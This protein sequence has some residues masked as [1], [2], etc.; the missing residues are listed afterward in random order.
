MQNA[1]AD[2]EAFTSRP[3]APDRYEVCMTVI[4]LRKASDTIAHHL[5]KIN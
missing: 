4:D 3:E 2:L 5:G 1:A